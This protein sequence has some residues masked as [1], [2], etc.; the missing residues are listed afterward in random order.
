MS[1]V[2]SG[3]GGRG[4]PFEPSR[5]AVRR[6]R[7]AAAEPRSKKTSGKPRGETVSPRRGEAATSVRS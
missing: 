3:S 2:N 6:G 4:K 7:T 1:F 5:I